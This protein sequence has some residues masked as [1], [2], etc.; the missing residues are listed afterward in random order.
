MNGLSRWLDQR[1]GFSRVATKQVNK[2]FPSHWSF[3][4]GEVTLYSFIVLLV[5]GAY[6]T[7]FFEPSARDVLYNGSYEPWR[8]TEMSAA[9]ASSL[10]ISFDVRSGL[11]MRQ[12]HHWSALLFIAAMVLHMMRVFFTGGFRRPREINWVIGVNI[13]I[14]SMFN[15][16]LGYSLLD[17]LL[18][19][20]G[21]RVAYNLLLS[22]PVIGP[23]MAFAVFG[24][25][26][27]QM[28]IIP[29]FFVIHVLLLPAAIVGLVGA[30]LGLV[31]FQKHT[32]HRGAG[33][34]ENNVVGTK[35]L[36]VFAMKGGALFFFVVAVCGLLAG[37]VQINP[38][39]VFGPFKGGE[40]VAAVTSAAQ[41][42]WYMGWM[43][44]V[45]RLIPGWETRVAGFLIPNYFWG[46]L[47]LPGIIF[48]GM[49]A[50][51]FIEPMW[52]KDRKQHNLL[53]RPRDYPFRTAFGAAV[54]SLMF[55][56]LLAGSNDVLGTIFH[57]APETIT[58]W[59]RIL[60]FVAPVVT[61]I[62]T[63]RI[64]LDLQGTD[65]HP[66]APGPNHEVVRTPD[67]G[68]EFGHGDHGGDSHGD[69]ATTA[70]EPPV[71]DPKHS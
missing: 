38:I 2:V 65:A 32:Q 68:Y 52:T 4:L 41:P 45:L 71:T 25:E 33:R 21:V 66:A 54:F 31:W 48:T 18:S 40:V 28:P 57:V 46:A 49:M 58:V 12:M 50:W 43:D 51:P 63:K 56:F 10:D 53:Q 19:G 42:D 7:F 1:L 62:V 60:V 37:T 6:L 3:M 30:H 29:R 11:V 34:T 14:L 67:G 35:I 23:H 70:A 15:G 61:Y 55:V 5:S 16:L 22:I 26:F 17:D 36:P 24:G 44:G 64:C 20:T 69:I 59:L 39:W 47:V 8:G 13:L 27:P 9:Y